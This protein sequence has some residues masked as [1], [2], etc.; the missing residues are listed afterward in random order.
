MELKYRVG[1]LREAG[2]EA[3]WTKTRSG[4]PIIVVRDPQGKDAHQRTQWWGVDE[5]MFRDMKKV[6]IREAFDNHTMF[7]GYFS[8]YM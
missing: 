7:G 3:K 2:L 6:G 8:Y 1:P 5:Q 4:Q